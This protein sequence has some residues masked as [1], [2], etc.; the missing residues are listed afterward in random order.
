MIQEG[1]IKER[2]TLGL[3]EWVGFQERMMQSV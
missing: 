3:E 2:L 1:F